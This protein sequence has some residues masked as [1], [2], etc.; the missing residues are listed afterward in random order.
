MR[1]K[2]TRPTVYFVLPSIRTLPLVGRLVR[3]RRGSPGTIPSPSI[4]NP[5]QPS[6]PPSVAH[7]SAAFL[8]PTLALVLLCCRASLARLRSSGVIFARLAIERMRSASRCS[9]VFLFFPR[10]SVPSPSRWREVGDRG[11]RRLWRRR[12]GPA[13]AARGTPPD[14]V[15][16]ALS[17]GAPRAGTMARGWMFRARVR[18]SFRFRDSNLRS[19][20]V[21]SRRLRRDRRRSFSRCST[22]ASARRRALRARSRARCS[23]V[24]SLGGTMMG[25][26]PRGASMVRVPLM[27]GICAVGGEGGRQRSGRGAIHAR[28]SRARG[29][30]RRDVV[31]I[32]GRGRR[33][34]RVRRRR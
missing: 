11:R 18:R 3:R 15:G 21:I 25:L 1:K 32:A 22:V 12:R 2:D 5:S 29:R 28:D 7:H 31:G 20:S 34:G 30:A 8:S 19:W 23:G 26:F 33:S 27:V 10:A 9:A 24:R 17:S 13:G 14:A 4:F 6:S 16:A